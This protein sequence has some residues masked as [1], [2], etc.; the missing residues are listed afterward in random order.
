[1]SLAVLKR[2]TNTKYS[3]ISSSRYSKSGFSLNNPRRVD[4]H[5]NQYQ[6]QTPMKGPVYRGH[7]SCCG[8]Y[9]VN[10]VKSR[11]NNYDNHVRQY[12]EKSNQ[13]ISVKTNR[14]SIYSRN[15]WINRPHP[16]GVTKQ[17]KTI[18]YEQYIDQKKGENNCNVVPNE[19]DDGCSD[20]TSSCKKLPVVHKD[21]TI[22][23][24]SEYMTTN[25]LKKNCLP[26]SG[27]KLPSPSP[28][29]G[30]CNSACK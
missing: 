6:I 19:E 10:V 30:R 28:I 14:A 17:M 9:P 5:S 13:G 25:L 20:N 29:S 15:K 2:K 12:S 16:Y 22:K 24:Q 21:V 27:D 1:M 11:Y 26:P 23:D 8:R 4:S 7:G 3:K 18:T